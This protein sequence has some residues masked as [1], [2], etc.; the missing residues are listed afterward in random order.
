MRHRW[1]VYVKLLNLAQLCWVLGI[2]RM[3]LSCGVQRIG[4]TGTCSQSKSHRVLH[5]GFDPISF[6]LRSIWY[7][8]RHKPG[9]RPKWLLLVGEPHIEAQICFSETHRRG[10]LALE[11]CVV[12]LETKLAVLFAK[13]IHTHQGQKCF[14]QREL[15]PG[16]TIVPQLSHGNPP[17]AL[18]SPQHST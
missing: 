4:V 3:K 14:Q 18:P 9:C 6:R 12:V 10:T 1:V 5:R 2:V 16:A 8:I 17:I 7:Q 11:R 13:K 15:F